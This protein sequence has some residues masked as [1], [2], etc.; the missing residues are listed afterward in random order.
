[1]NAPSHPSVAL[2][3][4]PNVGKSVVF[5]RLTGVH[6]ISSNYPGTTVGYSRGN[7][8][9]PS[10]LEDGGD[11]RF[12]PGQRIEIIDAPGVYSL[13][14]AS[15]S[16]RVAL[17]ILRDSDYAVCVVDSTNLERNLY[18]VLQVLESGVP[19]IVALNMWDETAHRG[20]KIDA[21]LLE[22]MLGV[23]VVP[24][25]GITGEGIREMVARLPQA[26]SPGLGP[27]SEEDRWLAI[28]RIVSR[29]QTLV[30]HHHTFLQTLSDLSV[31]P[32][33]GIPIAVLVILGAFS[34]VRLLGEFLVAGE[35][36]V[37]G[38]PFLKIGFG[39]EYLFRTLWVPVVSRLS[40]WLGGA[41]FVHDLLVGHLI[42]GR[43]DLMDSFGMLT[44][45]IFI[46]L[47]IVLPY[48]A[49]FYLVLSF[50]EDF[51]YLPRLAVL[52]DGVMHRVG[53][54]GYAIIPTLLGLGCNVPAI[55]ATRILESRR[56]RFLASTLISIA[57]PC[58]ALQA[59]VVGLLGRWGLRYVAAVYLAL[60]ATWL[61]LGFVLSRLVKGYS[62]EL[63]IEIPH[64]RLPPPGPFLRK[65]GVRVW[66]FLREALP[67]ILIGV[68]AVN[69]L[70]FFGVFDRLSRWAAPVVEGLLGLPRE[71][72]A[73]LAIGFL[74]KDMAVGMLEPLDLA[75]GQLV[76]ACTVLA[77][78]F[79]CVATFTVLLKELGTRD[80]LKSLAVMVGASLGVGT[81]LNLLI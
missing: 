9:W 27:L 10:D 43:V 47:G 51:G 31:R 2:V 44:T 22:E 29:V 76:V 58:A 16:D 12:R 39:T 45:G 5:Y 75:P 77:M 81:L 63:I 68:A 49:V 42:S 28:G 15:R 38:E 24:T 8:T 17:E 11:G 19:A 60:F 65:V 70:Y 26:R 20:V 33:T 56:E 57:V 73:A 36:G 59:M 13:D 46:P 25:V 48:V 61:G 14:A 67:V 52:L 1:V 30:H 35:V 21:P 3:G 69:V 18:F 37:W 32:W 40:E 64:Y 34:L 62:P 6:V 54:H 66:C 80:F 72:V 78:F 7:L 50:L 71:S 79:P 74:R 41:G 53:L 55:L 4:N 23:P